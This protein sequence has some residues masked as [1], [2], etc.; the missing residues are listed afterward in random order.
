MAVSGALVGPFDCECY[1]HPALVGLFDL[2]TILR[3]KKRSNNDGH[4]TRL[5]DFLRSLSST[6][7][8][9]ANIADFV[10]IGLIHNKRNEDMLDSILCT[11][12]AAYWWRFGGKRSSLIGDLS[13]GYMVTPHSSRTFAALP[14]TFRGRMN[15]ISP[16]TGAPAGVS[17]NHNCR[18][19]PVV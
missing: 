18:G 4:W 11:Y 7:L 9:I 5:I 6:E 17:P 15:P 16:S 12:V 10:P 2:D 8:P 1:P 3:Y 14:R 13:S 19:T